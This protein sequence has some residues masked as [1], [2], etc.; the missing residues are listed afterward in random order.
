MDL[1]KDKGLRYMNTH[2]KLWKAIQELDQ[3]GEDLTVRNV[4]RCAGVSAAVAYKHNCPE[5]IMEY[6][7]GESS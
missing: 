5:M 2:R 7:A 1:P 3:R 6:L 4:A